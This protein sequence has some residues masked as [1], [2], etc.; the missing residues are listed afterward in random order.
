MDVQTE[1]DEI[2]HLFKRRYLLTSQTA[3]SFLATFRRINSANSSVPKI[4]KK[5]L[6]CWDGMGGDVTCVKRFGTLMKLEAFIYD[7]MKS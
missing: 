7:V 3:V 2:F 5:D 1:H 6:V 4:G